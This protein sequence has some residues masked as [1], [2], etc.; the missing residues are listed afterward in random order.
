MRQA[1]KS[2][3][4]QYILPSGTP[5][6][7]ILS[8]QGRFRWCVEHAKLARQEQ[9][10]AT[11]AKYQETWRLR[12]RDLNLYRRGIYR[13]SR[14]I[15][16]LLLAN[17]PDEDVQFVRRVVHRSLREVFDPALARL[18]DIEVAAVAILPGYLYG[19]LRVVYDPGLIPRFDLP[20]WIQVGRVLPLRDFVRED[21]F[22]CTCH[23]KGKSASQ[24][25]EMMY[26]AFAFGLELGRDP[27]TI[28][29]TI[30]AT[31]LLRFFRVAL[32]YPM[33]PVRRVERGRFA[34]FDFG[35]F[36][37][38]VHKL[39]EGSGSSWKEFGPM[40]TPEKGQSWSE[41][42]FS[43][44][45]GMVENHIGREVRLAEIGDRNSGRSTESQAKERKKGPRD[46]KLS[47]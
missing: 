8:G 41:H 21:S 25:V 38:D 46:S 34:L 22:Y 37:A 31:G 23:T 42:M 9:C 44:F 20:W 13:N 28:S 14:A 29:L 17:F 11:N 24:I 10:A 43:C 39:A 45:W 18:N 4:C 33:F 27:D 30:L 40:G 36:D 35:D 3:R 7:A 19:V 15:S 5:C 47:L 16:H 32:M 6:G 1:N 2:L 12:H 26:K